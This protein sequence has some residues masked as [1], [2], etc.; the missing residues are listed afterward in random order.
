MSVISKNE[1]PSCN[2]VSVALERDSTVSYSSQSPL[3]GVCHPFGLAWGKFD[4]V[5]LRRH[6][7]LDLLGGILGDS[8]DTERLYGKARSTSCEN[9]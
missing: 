5:L 2:L 4:Q 3:L 1:M 7:A 8:R 6:E 9:G